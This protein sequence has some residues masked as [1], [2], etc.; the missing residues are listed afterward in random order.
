[1]VLPKPQNQKALTNVNNELREVSRLLSTMPEGTAS[2]FMCSGRLRIKGI[3]NGKPHFYN[4]QEMPLAKQLMYKKYLQIKKEELLEQ[5]KLLE[6][7]SDYERNWM[8]KA[9][10]YLLRNPVQAAMIA[11]FFTDKTEPLYQWMTAPDSNAA[12]YQEKRTEPTPASYRVRSKSEVMIIVVLMENGRFFRY[13]DPLCLSSKIYYPD[14]TIRDP[15]SGKTF[16]YEHFGKMDDPVYA[17][18]AFNKLADYAAHGIIPSVNL[19]VTFET[20]DNKLSFPQIQRALSI[21]DL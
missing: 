9:S 18:N 1:M 10:E 20:S 15:K 16:W 11:E 8:G 17:R 21:L 14:F 5:R 7:Q 6:A 12:P 4:Q 13:E 3:L 2:T 19:I